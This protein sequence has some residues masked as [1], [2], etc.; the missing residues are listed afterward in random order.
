MRW[1]RWPARSPGAF[2]LAAALLL[3]VL[4]PYGTTALDTFRSS[5]PTVLI[6]MI[7][8]WAVV[9]IVRS[10]LRSPALRLRAVA[11]RG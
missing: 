5:G 7:I 3:A 8:A 9:P 2:T 11:R 4:G 6:D 10:M 1:P